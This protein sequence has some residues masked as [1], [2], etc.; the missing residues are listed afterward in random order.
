MGI[1]GSELKSWVVC[2]EVEGFLLLLL[3]CR[4]ISCFRATI[5]RCKLTKNK[6]SHAREDA[7]RQ[8]HYQK[9]D[10]D[11]AEVDPKSALHRATVSSGCNHLVVCFDKRHLVV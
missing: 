9:Q 11:L 2:E 10:A 6:A 3:V 1:I 4:D 5:C 7:I 8:H